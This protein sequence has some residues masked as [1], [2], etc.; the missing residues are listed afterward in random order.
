MIVKKN[1]NFMYDAEIEITFEDV[2]NCFAECNNTLEIK[3]ALSNAWEI[4][5]AVP[6]KWISE[7]PELAK[8]AYDEIS[9]KIK[10]FKIA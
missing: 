10:R 6:D 7:N 5:R 2:K 3:K 1:I 9:D 4:I 8:K